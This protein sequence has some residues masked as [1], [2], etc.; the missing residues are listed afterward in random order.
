[1]EPS[2]IFGHGFADLM[3]VYKVCHSQSQGS[4]SAIS[5]SCPWVW[6]L[7]LSVDMALSFLQRITTQWPPKSS[8]C[9]M[10]EPSP[11]PP[12]IANKKTKCPGKCGW[13]L[14]AYAYEHW[15]KISIFPESYLLSNNCLCEIDY[16][17]WVMQVSLQLHFP[18]DLAPRAVIAFA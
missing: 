2:I 17:D 9:L 13:L 6:D 18:N 1:M 10:T 4:S 8:L 14:I 15:S 5:S 11:Q 12:S 3:M 16:K 7:W